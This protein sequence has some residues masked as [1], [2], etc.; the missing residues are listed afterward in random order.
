LEDLWQN[1][2]K[3]VTTVI[4]I[5]RIIANDVIRSLVAPQEMVAIQEGLNAG[6][7]MEQGRKEFLVL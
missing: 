7:V 2:V 1:I 4:A 3:N 6:F 5:V